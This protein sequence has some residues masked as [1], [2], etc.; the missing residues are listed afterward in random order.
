MSTPIKR[1]YTISPTAAGNLAR[2]GDNHVPPNACHCTECGWLD[3]ALWEEHYRKSTH[4][5]W[6]SM[7]FHLFD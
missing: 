5:E 4:F 7:Q 6:R 1:T 3:Y 2:G